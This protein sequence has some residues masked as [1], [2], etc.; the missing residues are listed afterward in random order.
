MQ[1]Q[2]VKKSGVQ[3]SI[4][5]HV[6]WSGRTAKPTALPK[7]IGSEIMR[8]SEKRT[9]DTYPYRNRFDL[10]PFVAAL[11]PVSGERKDIQKKKKR[12][13]EYMCNYTHIHTKMKRVYITMFIRKKA[14]YIIIAS[15]PQQRS[16]FSIFFKCEKVIRVLFIP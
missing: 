4:E 8:M 9:P 13:R 10:H 7:K 2:G 3:I 6:Q 16:V 1:K 12:K 15:F 14:C 11:L 5:T